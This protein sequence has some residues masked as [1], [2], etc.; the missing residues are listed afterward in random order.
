MRLLDINCQNKAIVNLI[1]IEIYET[2][3]IYKFNC[4][5][6]CLVKAESSPKTIF[7]NYHH[8]PFETFIL[9]RDINEMK[10]DIEFCLT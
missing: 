1:A 7:H 3:N 2:V 6:I 9:M 5:I 10:I 4:R 8:R